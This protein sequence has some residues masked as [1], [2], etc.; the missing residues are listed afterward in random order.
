MR[1]LPTV[2]ARS[3]LGVQ[4]VWR[5][6]TTHGQS[7]QAW[8]HRAQHTTA[9]PSHIAVVLFCL[10]LTRPPRLAQVTRECLADPDNPGGRSILT[11]LAEVARRCGAKFP[12]SI[13]YVPPEPEPEAEPSSD[14]GLG[15]FDGSDTEPP[16]P[17]PAGNSSTPGG[18]AGGN[19]PGSGPGPEPEP[20]GRQPC[21]QDQLEACGGD[22]ECYRALDCSTCSVEENATITT[23][24]LSWSS[25]GRSYRSK[26]RD[27]ADSLPHSSTPGGEA[28]GNELE[29]GPGPEP[30]LS[31]WQ[32][33]IQDQLEA[34][35][36]DVECYRALDCS[37]C[38]VEENATIPGGGWLNCRGSLPHLSVPGGDH[39]GHRRLVAV[40]RAAAEEVVEMETGTTEM[41]ATHDATEET[42]LEQLSRAE[43]VQMLLAERRAA[44]ELRES[45]GN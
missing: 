23:E 34:C 12:N 35:G 29:P 17:E 37:T 21:V 43:L 25:S 7:A 6:T 41:D 40:A 15:S 14:S 3:Q 9:A 24:Y 10:A 4:A 42:E 13:E 5:N 30:E 8:P 45:E 32:P 16:G 11:P 18:E 26:C 1:P 27:S 36:G 28:G 44:A 33:C 22:V 2:G 20:P 31:G 39:D 38:S 19:G